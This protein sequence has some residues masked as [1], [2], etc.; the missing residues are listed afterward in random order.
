MRWLSVGS[1][2]GLLTRWKPWTAQGV[3]AFI[4]YRKWN[5]RYPPT[6]EQTFS[7][8]NGYIIHMKA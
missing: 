3:S 5:V 8:E 4:R 6:M 7:E 1:T 2:I